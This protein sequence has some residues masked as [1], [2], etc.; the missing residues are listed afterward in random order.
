MAYLSNS[1]GGNRALRFVG[2]EEKE[3]KLAHV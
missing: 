1:L 2:G 3:C